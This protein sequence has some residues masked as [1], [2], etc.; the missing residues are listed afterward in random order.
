MS[1]LV[2]IKNLYFIAMKDNVNITDEDRKTFRSL[3]LQDDF[4]RAEIIDVPT[5]TALLEYFDGC[6]YEG[7]DFV[8]DTE[9]EMPTI[10]IQDDYVYIGPSYR[11]ESEKVPLLLKKAGL[12]IKRNQLIAY[13]APDNDPEH[14]YALV[15]YDGTPFESKNSMCNS[16]NEINIEIYD[17]VLAL[18]KEEYN[19]YLRVKELLS[20]RKYSEI[21]KQD[22]YLWALTDTF[23]NRQEKQDVVFHEIRHAQNRLILFD[24]LFD[25]PDCKLSGVDMFK[26][27]QDDELSA[28][29]SE[30]IQAINTYNTS[31]DKNDLSVFES[32]YL[33]QQLLYNK[34]V[35]G[36]ERLLSDMP[37][38][39][40]EIC[41]YW[42]INFFTEY[43]PQFFENL[44][45]KFNR[46]TLNHLAQES[47]GRAY[48]EIRKRMF[49]YRV[50][51][52]N[53]GKYE[54]M[55]LSEYVFDAM[56]DE[57][58]LKTVQE[59]CQNIV[60]K[61]QKGMQRIHERVQ[62]NLLDVTAKKYK[63]CVENTEYRKTLA[64][65]QRKGMNYMTALNFVP[66]A[67]DKQNVESKNTQ[68]EITPEEKESFFKKALHK[69]EEK[70]SLRQH[71][72]QND[73]IDY[74]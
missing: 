58:M 32:S 44:D 71:H 72:P 64:E 51:N 57:S 54:N 48:K 16:T 24:Y 46:L 27:C 15:K 74:I 63:N 26:Q 36:R 67:A 9:K 33:L 38:I 19:T 61:R 18:R 31:E 13:I 49:T 55:D 7:S 29:I 28:K 4:F 1:Q 10:T 68:E 17:D 70:I 43:M 53:T 2:Q 47:D 39:I 66:D 41:M 12:K 22:R 14:P 8:N 50:Y 60:V 3:K 5:S 45:I 37:G 59:I 73:G 65:L 56:I 34:T 25:N 21:S 23:I 11:V 30:A 35:E 42:Y 52:V 69:I 40:Y 62:Y 6:P 20:N